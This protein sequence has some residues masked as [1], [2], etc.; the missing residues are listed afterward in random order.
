MELAHKLVGELVGHVQ[1]P[2]V[3]SRLQPPADDAVLAVHDVVH[4]A[5]LPLVHRRQGVDAPPGLILVRP[6]GEAVPG[7]VGGLPGLVGPQAGVGAVPV[8]VLAHEAL[9][10]EHPVQH[11]VHAPGPGGGAQQGEVLVGAQHG[12]H[13]LVVAGA[14]AVVLRSLKDGA[15]VDR[16]HP[17]AFEVVQLLH[18][19]RQG[20]AEEVPVADLAPLVGPPHRLLEPAGVDTAAPHHAGGVGDG[21]AAEAVGED[22]IGDPL[23]EPG[24][25]LRGA[26]VDGELPLGELQGLSVQPLQLE[27]VPHQAQVAGG[28]Q[29]AGEEVP[30]PV[31]P[32]PAE[33]DGEDLVLPE[34]EPGPE[35]GPGPALPAEGTEGKFHRRPRGRRPEGPLAPEIPG[36]KD[37][38][39]CQASSLTI[40]QNGAAL[41][42]AFGSTF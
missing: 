28:V 17:Q 6:V 30:V 20:A 3:G 7:V 15:E 36:V 19:P 42:G 10:V 12:V 16:L 4:I 27:G 26:V 31:Q 39:V 13:L 1:P 2:A 40:A 34:L 32:R 8:E 11:D 25:H 21:G 5:L 24:G 18:D 41:S 35:H 23:P 9:V 29:G 38:R 37:R 33:G 22:L 14:I